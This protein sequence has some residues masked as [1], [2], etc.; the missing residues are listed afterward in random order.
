M[1][2][3]IDTIRKGIIYAGKSKRKYHRIARVAVG[4]ANLAMQ[5]G[6]LSGLIGGGVPILG[7]IL[8]MVFPLVAL[9]AKSGQKRC[10][11]KSEGLYT[12]KEVPK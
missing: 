3:S 8:P 11:Y 12:I 9:A 1:S 5:A 4:A 10:Q 2:Q 7:I 6:P